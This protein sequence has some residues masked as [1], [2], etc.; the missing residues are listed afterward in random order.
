MR[1]FQSRIVALTFLQSRLLTAA[2]EAARELG[3]QGKALTPL[4]GELSVCDLMNLRW[5]PSDGF[6]ALSEDGKNI[7]SKPEGLN[8]AVSKEQ[9]LV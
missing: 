3:D 5:S 7:K 1:R 4:I 2:K 6:D 8:P 9:I